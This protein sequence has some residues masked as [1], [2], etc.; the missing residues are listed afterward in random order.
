M[1]LSS[2]AFNPLALLASHPKSATISLAEGSMLFE[3]GAAATSIYVLKRGRVEL[4]KHHG[5]RACYHP[6]EV[7]CLQDVVWHQGHHS[8]VA[9]AR[10]PI[11]VLALER[12]NFLHML[13]HHPTFALW[14][15][16]QQDNCL[17]DHRANGT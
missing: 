14:L 3:R 4:V 13:H 9:L 17:W 16:G 5:G 8:A 12:L 7:F 10:T 15:I 2:T 6:G 1:T 11:E